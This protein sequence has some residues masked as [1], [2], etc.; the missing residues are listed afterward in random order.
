MTEPTGS[1]INRNTNDE[2][3]CPADVHAEIRLP[4]TDLGEDIRFFTKTLGFRLDMIFPADDPAAAIVSGYGLQVR[5]ER[6][7]PEAPGTIRLL[8]RDPAAFAG[9][10][11]ELTAPNGTRIEI[12]EARPP[13]E[14]P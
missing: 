5:L 1:K 10:R 13:L 6:G 8:C 14:I 7:A 11:T 3:A 4:A 12:V 2:T 9:G